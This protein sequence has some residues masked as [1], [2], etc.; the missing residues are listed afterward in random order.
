M[1]ILLKKCSENK[2]CRR[3]LD[4]S[5]GFCIYNIKELIAEHYYYY[6]SECS[7]LIQ[8]LLLTRPNPKLKFSIFKALF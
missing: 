7:T 1:I 5:V 4:Y 8:Y 6:A 2:I 3:T